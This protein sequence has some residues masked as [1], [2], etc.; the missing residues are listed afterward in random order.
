M[1]K[2]TL[3]LMIVFSVLVVTSYPCWAQTVIYGCVTKTSGDIRIVATPGSCKGNEALLTW[4][5]I[6]PT[7]PQG[8]TGLTG[9]VGAT[10][11]QGPVGQTG[12]MGATGATG[13]I[14]PTGPAG[15]TGPKGDTGLQGP[16]GVANGIN[17]VVYGVVQGAGLGDVHIVQGN[18]FSL[19]NLV[20]GIYTITFDTPF[21]TPPTCVAGIGGRTGLDAGCAAYVVTTLGLTIECERFSASMPL[22]GTPMPNHDYVTIIDTVAYY[23]PNDPLTFICVQ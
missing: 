4:N 3:I 17:R 10:G 15:A 22:S 19:Q 16:A 14:G 12:A 8:P 5:N 18:E 20:F 2:K 6:G 7:G 11:P 1:R 23:Q 9:A 21:P 13:A